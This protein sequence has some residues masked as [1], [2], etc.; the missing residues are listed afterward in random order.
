MKKLYLG[1]LPYNVSE[2]DIKGHFA[3][4][5]TIEEASLLKTVLPVT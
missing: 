1:N 4:F 3:Q 2:D 5:G